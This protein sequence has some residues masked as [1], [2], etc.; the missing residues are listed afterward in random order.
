S[1]RLYAKRFINFILIILLISLFVN[2]YISDYFF[3]I[4]SCQ[5]SKRLFSSTAKISA[6]FVSTFSPVPRQT[7]QRY[8]QPSSSASI[9]VPSHALHTASVTVIPPSQLL[10]S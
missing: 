6:S 8:C 3:D 2:F 1:S 4:F 10:P 7:L 9:P 5:S